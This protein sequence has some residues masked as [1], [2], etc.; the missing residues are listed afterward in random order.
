MDNDFLTFLAIIS[1]VVSFA[2]LSRYVALDMDGRGKA[3]WAY[4]ILTFILPPLGVG[5]WLLDR[6]RPPTRTE[7]R[8]ELGGRADLLLFLLFIVTFPWGLVI[9]LFL[10]RRASPKAHRP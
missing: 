1:Y 4:G 6:N 3:G 8:P 7:L 9:W 2:W 5:L 10:N